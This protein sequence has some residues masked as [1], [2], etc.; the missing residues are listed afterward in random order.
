VSRGDTIAPPNA[1]DILESQTRERED[2][3]NQPRHKGNAPLFWGIV[4]ELTLF[5]ALTCGS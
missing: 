4:L 5:E 3:G 1:T 2:L